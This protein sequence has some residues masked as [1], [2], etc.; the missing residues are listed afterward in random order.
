MEEINNLKL[1]ELYY[2]VSVNAIHE[3]DIV[4]YNIDLVW[5]RINSYYKKEIGLSL[6][7]TKESQR[8]TL[9]KWLQSKTRYDLLD[10][11]IM[12]VYHRFLI[13]ENDIDNT[14]LFFINNIKSMVKLMDI[15]QNK[16][17]M[18]LFSEENICIPAIS[19]KE[20]I[21]I[22]K[23]ILEEIDP[24]RDWLS[25]Y[26]DILLKNRIV[27]L[28]ELSAEETEAL[29][30]RFE[31]DSIKEITNSCL[32][33]NKIEPCLFLDYTGTIADIPNTIHEIVHYIIR[34]NNQELELPTLKEYPSI[35]FEMY[36]V[37]YL[38]KLGYQDA[39]L[40]ALNSSR[41]L[42]IFLAYEDIKDVLY[43]LMLIIEK[44]HITE[45][46]DRRKY[47]AFLKE[48]K[49][50][51][52]KQDILHITKEDSNFFNANIKCQEKCDKVNYNLM[53]NPL[54]LFQ[55]YPYLIGA[56]LSEQSMSKLKKSKT[57]LAMIK[58]ITEKL[59]NL[60]AYDIFS[61]LDCNIK[62]LVPTN[63]TEDS[64]KH[65]RRVRRK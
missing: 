49:R 10:E 37:D 15:Y 45:R 55:R 61:I 48:L 26:E 3:G 9:Y 11:L 4:P 46:N 58:Y 23:D 56:Y 34:E 60:D 21:Q 40:K 30:K 38:K 64:D 19:K 13:V 33:T 39:E 42:D 16:I 65:K 22:V 59:S 43:Y 6:D 32:Y 17:E 41:A 54:L 57:T 14:D 50:T 47:N 7:I 20:T 25:I 63:Y 52:S 28:N 35:F 24:N 62:E 5:Q 8:D 51:L 53:T 2:L 36:A 1:S 31:V 27:Y 44:G 12:H 29:K 18:E